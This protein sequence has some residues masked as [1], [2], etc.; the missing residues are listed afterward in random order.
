MLAP[1]SGGILTRMLVPT[2][3]LL[4]GPGRRCKR[5]QR[6]LNWSEIV[7]YA[8]D[9]RLAGSLYSAASWRTG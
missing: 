4:L 1:A 2:L 9:E 6:F 3:N 5:L 7:L 8:R